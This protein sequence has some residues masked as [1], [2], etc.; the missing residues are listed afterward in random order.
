[1]FL[2]LDAVGVL[3]VGRAKET[4]RVLALHFRIPWGLTAWEKPLCVLLSLL[5]L[6]IW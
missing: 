3:V 2:F 4:E 1:M 5:S 6:S